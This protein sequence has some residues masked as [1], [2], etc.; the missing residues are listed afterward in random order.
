[1]VINTAFTI[2]ALDEAAGLNRRW[3]YW[4]LFL[5]RN[6]YGFLIYVALHVIALGNV[7][8]DLRSPTHSAV[9]LAAGTLGTCALTAFP[10]WLYVRYRRKREQLI[11]K[12]GVMAISLSTEGLTIRE[13]NGVSTSVPWNAYSGFREGRH[14]FALRQGEPPDFVLY[15]KTPKALQRCAR[16]SYR[17]CP[18]FPD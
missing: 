1:M 13:Q 9:V 15:P 3:H 18:K 11:S 8:K 2:D 10:I 7:I 5:A 16:Y 14:I 12:Q 4:P 17:N 6:A